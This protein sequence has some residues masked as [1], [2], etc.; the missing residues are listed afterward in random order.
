MLGPAARQICPQ[1]WGHTQPACLP[2]MD[3]SANT[4]R[5]IAMNTRPTIPTIPTGN[6]LLHPGTAVALWALLLSGESQLRSSSRTLAPSPSLP[7]HLS[8]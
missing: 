8:P 6:T 5:N 2:N 4:D 3:P 1:L 7:T